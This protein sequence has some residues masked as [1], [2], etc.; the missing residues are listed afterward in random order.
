FSIRVVDDTGEL[1]LR[2]ASP[3]LPPAFVNALDAISIADCAAPL[4]DAARLREP[5]VCA[6]IS[7]VANERF[8]RFTARH[9]IRSAWASP[10]ISGPTGRLLGAIAGYGE[11]VGAPTH[12]QRLLT[13]MAADVTAIAI[14]RQQQDQLLA[15]QATS[16]SLTGLPN[17]AGILDQLDR[18][19]HRAAA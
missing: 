3:S 12:E 8:A 5:V 13:Q 6:D 19:L 18:A 1:L 17:R 16:D 10:I 7:A 2:G 9:G 4:A 11:H 14:E 15:H